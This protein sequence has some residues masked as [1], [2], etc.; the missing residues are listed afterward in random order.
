MLKFFLPNGPWFSSSGTRSNA[1][2]LDVLEEDPLVEAAPLVPLAGRFRNDI[3]P[4]HALSS[5]ER[6]QDFQHVR[7]FRPQ[8]P[9]RRRL[10][11]LGLLHQLRP[12]RRQVPGLVQHVGNG[13]TAV[14]LDNARYPVPDELVVIEAHGL[15]R[16]RPALTTSAEA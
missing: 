5:S 9:V 13:L 4:A 12:Q 15:K 10:R 16:Y 3:L 14:R 6:P 11:L 8:L 2:L 7:Q 1:D